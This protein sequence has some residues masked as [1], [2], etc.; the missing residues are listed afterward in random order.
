MLPN[1]KINALLELLPSSQY[2]SVPYIECL[3]LHSNYMR[4]LIGIDIRLEPDK[5]NLM[6]LIVEPDYHSLV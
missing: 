6:G 3:Q 5:P 1:M 2:D 4:N